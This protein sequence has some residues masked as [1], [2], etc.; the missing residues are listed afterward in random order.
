MV[1]N[2]NKVKE[3]KY[4][5]PATREHSIGE[6]SSSRLLTRFQDIFC[7]STTT[8]SQRQRRRGTL[9]LTSCN[10]ENAVQRMHDKMQKPEG[11]ADQL[12]SVNWY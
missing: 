9:H 6:H 8:S 1:I 5:I 2:K 7:I 12:A 11:P 3:L 4:Y 10:L